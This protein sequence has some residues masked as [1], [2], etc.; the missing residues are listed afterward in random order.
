MALDELLTQD[1]ILTGLPAKRASMLLF[2]IESQTA[3]LVAQSR[4]AMERFL[5]AETAEERDLAFLEAFAWGK[6]PPIRPTIQDMEHYAGQ[7]KYLVPHNP[8]VQAAIAHVLGQKY[9]FTYRAVPGLCAALGLDEDAVQ[10]GYRRLYG[11]P[12]DTIFASRSTPADRLRWAFG[13]FSKWVASLPPFWTAFALTLTE[14][15]G[16]G[17][18]ALPIAMAGV[19]P[20]AGVVILI[21]LGLVNILTIACMAEAIS[22][23]GLVHYGDAFIGRVVEDYLGSTGS[24][25]L[26]LGMAIICFLALLAYYIGFS[27]TLADVT[28][29]PAVVW[30]G[31][32]FLI[33]VYFVRRESLDATV[34]SSLLVGFINIGL[35]LI[36]SLVAFVHMQPGN[37][38]YVNVPFINGRPFDPSILQLVFGVVLSAYFGHLSMSNCARAVIRQEPSGRS[39]IWGCMAA[40]GMVLI[41]YCVWVLAANSAIA[42]QDLA[43]QSGTA[44]IPLAAQAGPIVSVLGA[45]FVVLGMGLASIHFSLGLYNLVRERLPQKTPPVLVLPRRRGQLIFRQRGNP[46]GG[47]RIGLVYLGLES[48]QPTFRL[49]VQ[50]AGAAHH[51][52]AAATGQWD[53]AKLL[54]Q[55]PDVRQRSARLDVE[56][57]EANQEIARLRVASPMAMVYEGSRDS[58]GLDIV[59]AFTLP[60]SERHLL[61]WITRQGE[62]S[63]AEIA[64]HMGQDE[65]VARRIVTALVEQGFMRETRLAGELRYRTR[66]APKRGRR[67]TPEIWRALDEPVPAEKSPPRRVGNVL[68]SKGGRFWLSIS[69]IVIVFLLAEWQ[70]ATGSESFTQPI[71]FIGALVIPLLGGIFPVL[72]LISGRRKG[73]FAPGVKYEFLG[74]PLVAAGIYLFFLASLFL[75]G[76]VIWNNPVQRALALAAAVVTVGM[77]IAMQQRGSFSPR[78]VVELRKDAGEDG[79]VVFAVST[80][81][82]PWMADVRLGYP[83]GEQHYQAA[84]GQSP[85]FAS[86]RYA[87]FQLS[88]GPA[89]ELKVW[90]HKITPE[91]DSESLPALVEL[92]RGDQAQQFDVRLSGGQAVF[93]LNDDAFQLQIT[94]QETP[95]EAKG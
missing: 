72:L 73:E 62:A 36:L 93:P 28:R 20:L 16:A 26:S 14:T 90:A 21:V 71:S 52:E 81:G 64:A 55:F 25:I 2:L 46:D 47:P 63:M 8:Q 49:D 92:R 67:A 12:L 27:T 43:R 9:S 76:L 65:A 3:R 38:V 86:L 1:E 29:I 22:R 82:K 78:M 48:G 17:V 30:V 80:G 58:V 40:Q 15:V 87:A 83:D 42:P 70:L 13:A 32:L 79:K 39:L 5:T 24:L 61:N 57:L 69:P 94:L 84:S 44:L 33:G 7:W 18:L 77:T 31:L 45:I 91:G 19:G 51:L 53:A 68:L 95:Q 85:A 56:I 50:L 66:L 74:H 11:K 41:L 4:Q 23:S 89:G 59:D 37:L 10:R 60:E 34:A 88:P 75:H 54:E 35:V 6:P